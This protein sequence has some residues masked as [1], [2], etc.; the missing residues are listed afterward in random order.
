[1][2]SVLYVQKGLE[3]TPEV[4]LDPNKLSADG[5]SLLSSATFSRDG[6]YLAYGVSAGGSD[7][8]EAYVM[9]VASRRVLPDHLKWLK[10]TG[11]SWAG[12]GLFYSR[13]AAPEAGKEM[14][15]KNEFQ[16]VWLHRV[17]TDQA[18]DRRIYE[19]LAHAQRFNQCYTTEDER[20]AILTVSDRGTGKKGNALFFRD[21]TDPDASFKPLVPEISDDSW[22]VLD[23][24][25]T[26]FLLQ[27]NNKAPNGRVAHF[28]IANGAW[29]T[30]I[31]EKPEALE[32][33]TTGGGKIFALY[34]KD[35]TTQVSVYSYEGKPENSVPMPGLGTGSGFGGRRDDTSVFYSFTSLN[36][37]SS[38]FRYDVASKQ[39][40]PFRVPA[41]PGFDAGN[42]ESKEVFVRSKDGTLV[43]MFLVYKRGLKLDGSNPA[44]LTGYGGFS[45]TAAPTFDPLRIALLEQGFVF[46]SANMRG[47]AE[48]G[49]KW[50]EAGTKLKKQN[51]FDDFI[52]CAEWLIANKYTAPEHFAAN[53]TSNGGLLIGAVINQRPD[54]FRVAIPQAGVMDMLR[55]QKFTI[56]WNWAPDYGLSDNP[57]EFRAQR[58]YSPIHNVKRGAKYPSVLIT[59]ADHDDR[60]VPAHS[61][62][63]AAAMQ[64]GVSPER[65]VLIRIETNSGHGASST[66]KAIEIR[67]DVYAFALRELGLTPTLP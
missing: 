9:E 62:K 54:L 11:L 42:Y 51:V 22:E 26:G 45:V 63:Y 67:S 19:D 14:S 7:W 52:A 48:Y 65:P 37:P 41:I 49:E 43:P 34:N 25:A 29:T 15:A 64:D 23:S 55:Y 40:T 53:G 30:I 10:A 38:I 36:Y 13:Y 24:T 50:H 17:G 5:T 16:T 44:W 39:S 32:S 3:G 35:V 47:G 21:L 6:R 66:Q 4:L 8:H 31:P 46:A 1:N 60:V 59:T 33:A 57:E 28:A 12:D 18:E 56:G 27:T 58:A 61:F 20:Y 2:Q